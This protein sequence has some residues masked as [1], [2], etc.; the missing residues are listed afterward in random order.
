VICVFEVIGDPSI[1]GVIRKVASL[2]RVLPTFGFRVTKNV[3]CLKWN[4]N[5]FTM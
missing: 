4:S 2:V 3:V 1:F 5:E